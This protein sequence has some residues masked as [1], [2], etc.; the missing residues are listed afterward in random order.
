MIN[1]YFTGANL[2]EL[3]KAQ[4]WFC[5]KEGNTPKEIGEAFNIKV[6][7]VKNIIEELR[8][9]RIIFNRLKNI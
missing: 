6:Q 2:Y 7:I 3:K 4:I 8:Q 9:E 1:Y 5:H